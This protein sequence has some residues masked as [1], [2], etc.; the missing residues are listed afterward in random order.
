[1]LTVPRPM[2]LEVASAG[3]AGSSESRDIDGDRCG[4]VAFAIKFAAIEFDC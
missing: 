1:M 2:A 3:D 4:F